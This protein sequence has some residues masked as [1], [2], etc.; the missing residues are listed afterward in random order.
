MNVTISINGGPELPVA[1]I[2]Y[3]AEPVDVMSMAGETIPDPQWSVTDAAGH[4]HAWAQGDPPTLPTLHNTEG[5]KRRKLYCKLCHKRIRPGY[6]TTPGDSFRRF[7]VG[8]R[9]WTINISAMAPPADTPV[10]GWET[11]SIRLTDHDDGSIRF[12]LGTHVML[13]QITSNDLSEQLRRPL[14]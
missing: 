4:Y 3:R 2:D 13:G 6:A 9:E 12:G 1:S 5:T 11:L 7:I 14:S 8:W 10:V